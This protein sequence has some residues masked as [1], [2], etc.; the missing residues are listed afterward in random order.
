MYLRGM[1]YM[2]I[3]AVYISALPKVIAGR[4]GIVMGLFAFAFT[5]VVMLL[6]LGWIAGIAF[7]WFPS[8]LAGWLTAVGC[9]SLV[10]RLLPDVLLSRSASFP[11]R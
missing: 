4:V 3:K 6:Q 2:D 10:M 8:A 1:D 5:Y 7:G 11:K 9:D